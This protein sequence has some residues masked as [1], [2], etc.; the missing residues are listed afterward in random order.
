[1][2]SAGNCWK[3][4]H[5]THRA[6]SVPSFWAEGAF[7]GLA[8]ANCCNYRLVYSGKLRWQ[9]K[10]P[11]ALMHTNHTQPAMIA[12]VRNV[13]LPLAEDDNWICCVCKWIIRQLL[14]YINRFITGLISQIQFWTI[15]NW[16]FC[17]DTEDV[18]NMHIGLS[19]GRPAVATTR[20]SKRKWDCCWWWVSF[21]AI[22]NWL[23]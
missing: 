13:R 17:V 20:F 7:C 2:Q 16:G 9:V 22:S 4:R 21:N 12:K 1:M 19:A 8:E 6:H 11:N 10:A 3:C 15:V 23:F 14:G 5:S 18:I